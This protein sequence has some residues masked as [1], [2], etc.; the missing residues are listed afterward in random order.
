[1]A[2]KLEGTKYSIVGVGA[3]TRSL[4]E[5][6]CLTR[7]GGTANHTTRLLNVFFLCLH[8]VLGQTVTV[9]EFVPCSLIQDAI[10]KPYL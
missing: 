1:M 7:A 4:I 2:A 9:F 10:V 5:S 8:S 3:A 6:A